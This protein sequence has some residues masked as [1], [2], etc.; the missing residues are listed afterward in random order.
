MYIFI[1]L[2]FVLTW[3]VLDII[4][5]VEKDIRQLRRMIKV[6]IIKVVVMRRK[7]SSEVL[8]YLSIS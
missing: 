3:R 2:I 8:R 4:D 6:A 7:K 1:Y 5:A